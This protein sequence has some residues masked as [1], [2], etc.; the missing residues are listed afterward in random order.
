MRPTAA[1]D[2]GDGCITLRTRAVVV[3][4][5]A[6]LVLGLAVLAGAVVVGT[7]SLTLAAAAGILGLAFVL[8]AIGRLSAWVEVHPDRVAWTWGFARHEVAYDDVVDV[9]L[10]PHRGVRTVLLVR[11]HG[12]PV[13]VAALGTFGLSAAAPPT[14]VDQ[15]LLQWAVGEHRALATTGPRSG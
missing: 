5:V 4:G 2:L 6:D 8:G 3:S 10:S 14:F 11:R 15:Q 9:T 13:R 12:P 1:E 7:R